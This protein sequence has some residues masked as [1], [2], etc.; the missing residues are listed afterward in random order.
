MGFL[1]I[2]NLANSQPVINTLSENNDTIGQFQKFEL[3]LDLTATYINPFDYSQ[4]SI[5][6]IFTSP[7]N[8]VDT[9][10]GFYY[11]N[12]TLNIS[13]GALT[14]NG[15][16]QWKIRY[17]PKE[18]GTY[19]YII[20]CADTEGTTSSSSTNFLCTNSADHGFVRKGTGNYLK[21]DD[22]TSYFAV[23]ENLCWNDST[24]LLSYQ[25]WMDSLEYNKA[26]F[27]RLWMASWSLGIEW[28]DTTLGNYSKRLD[29]AYELDQIA[30]YA[31]QKG[32]YFLLSLVSHGQFS[33]TVNSEWAN[34]P[35]NSALGGPCSNTGAF[36]TNTT[37]K[38]YFKRRLRYINSRWGYS[39]YLMTWE[40]FNEVNWVDNFSSTKTQIAAWHSEMAQYIRKIDVNDH[41]IST[42]I[43][44]APVAEL[45][46]LPEMDY[47][48][49]H[50]YSSA[51][52][53][54][55]SQVAALKDNVTAFNK[56]V[57]L[58][59][60]GFPGDGSFEI[61]NDPTGINFHNTMWASAFSGSFGS[62]AIWWWDNYV[63]KYNIYRHMKAVTAFAAT[64]NYNAENYQPA[65]GV[66]TTASSMIDYAVSPGYSSFSKC[67]EDTFTVSSSGI[68]PSETNLGTFL[69]GSWNGTNRNPPTF[70]VNY[71]VADSFIVAT[72]TSTGTGPKIKIVLDGITKV[73]VNAFVNKRYG[74]LV[75]AGTH[76][77]FVDNSS[78]QDWIT[79]AEYIFKG[80]TPSLR[81]V[82]LKNSNKIIGWAQNRNY[83]WKYVK[84]N[85]IPASITNGTINFTG[86]NT[87]GGYDVDWVNCTTG[88]IDSS[89]VAIAP[90]GNLNLPVYNL[91]W[92][93]G[94]KLTYNPLI[95]IN[96]KNKTLNSFDVYPNPFSY[97]VTIN[98]NLE[99]NSQVKISI[100]DALGREVKILVSEKQSRVLGS[101]QQIEW[102]GTNEGGAK[103]EQGIYL[104]KLSIDENVEYI[105]IMLH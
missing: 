81:T 26:S 27:I 36:F 25:R 93:R 55:S 23:G 86:L 33:T 20:K 12:Y 50:D 22:N 78:T 63:D 32:I 62:G 92:D 76:T 14:K 7:A 17:S 15:T 89:T 94:F 45:W 43:A 51:S 13:T 61:T 24:R 69:F 100:Y 4:I 77:I 56:P 70:L 67:T 105:K 9:V 19:S 104:C 44:T 80:Y 58:G 103:L 30:D 54:Q 74:I 6:G 99:G 59:E 38:N 53:M 87:T 47:T 48:Q 64:E 16:P 79:I 101:R 66:T 82:A 18:T 68:T 2:S 29:R 52:D 31:Q 95:T 46:N 3:S 39:P 83:N 10:D 75:P 60:F 57:L 97:I 11:Q 8:V 35:Y 42:S 102:D 49:I 90:A 28:N 65:N 72:G 84:D 34:C 40:L 41:L 85:G 21:F 1:I 37:A 96:E 71:A 98:Y 73:N 88:L 5:Q 91:A